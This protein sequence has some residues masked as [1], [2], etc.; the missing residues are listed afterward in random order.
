M[1]YITNFVSREC[2]LLINWCQ[3]QICFRRWFRQ[4][5]INSFSKLDRKNNCIS[6]SSLFNF[7][8]LHDVHISYVHTV[9][10][11]WTFTIR[12]KVTNNAKRKISGSEYHKS[13]FV[14]SFNPKVYHFDRPHVH[15][16]CMPRNNI[17]ENLWLQ[18]LHTSEI[19]QLTSRTIS[20]E[21]KT[22]AHTMYK[23]VGNIQILKGI[24]IRL[25]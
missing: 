18:C 6:M 10:W 21:K 12:T 25:E 7:S 9:A 13:A 11:H 17:K 1:P 24:A 15:I 20:G 22:C 16:F 3:Q 5:D 19:L 4:F 8:F 14:L 2:M 23:L